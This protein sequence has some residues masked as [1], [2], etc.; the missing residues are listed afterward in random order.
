MTVLEV[1][2]AEY[3]FKGV[4]NLKNKPSSKMSVK[5]TA[6]TNDVKT[7]YTSSRSGIRTQNRYV[8]S[9]VEHFEDLK[10]VFGADNVKWETKARKYDNAIFECDEKLVEHKRRH[11]HEFNA[12]SL[13]DY[14]NQAR[15]VMCCGQPFL[16]H[17]C[18]NKSTNIYPHYC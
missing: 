2:G 8:L 11:G 3:A 15:D 14:L 6:V 4:K 17:L 12:Y 16:K 1:V 10:S 5:T 18:L 13:D 7:T 9:G